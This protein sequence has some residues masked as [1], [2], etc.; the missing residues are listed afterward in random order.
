M[1]HCSFVNRAAESRFHLEP[2]RLIIKPERGTSSVVHC[3]H[4]T[5]IK[6]FKFNFDPSETDE[7]SLI[8][9]TKSEA[10]TWKSVN[11]MESQ[12]DGDNGTGT[13]KTSLESSRE[14]SFDDLVCI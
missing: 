13:A 3:V 4:N 12:K 1:P 9:D 10:E 6:M 5:H 14:I 8:Q 11:F 2:H 7:D